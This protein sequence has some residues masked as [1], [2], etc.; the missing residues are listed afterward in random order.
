MKKVRFI[1]L[2]MCAIAFTACDNDKEFESTEFPVNEQVMEAFTLRYPDAVNVT[3]T[4]KGEYL[5]ANFD[6]DQTVQSKGDSSAEAH[7]AWFDNH[8]KWYMTE[9]DIPFS[10]LPE[11]VKTA[12]NDSEYSAAP[13]HVEDVDMLEREGMETIYVIEVENH[14][15]GIESEIVLYYSGDGI[16]VKMI[17]DSETDYDYSDYIPSQAENGITEFINARYPDARITEI[18][19]EHGMTEV[20]I[21]D[22]RV[23]RELLFDAH[24]N[25]L[26]TKTKI[27]RSDCPEIVL[28][29]LSASEYSSLRIDD[30]VHYSTPDSEYYRV[31]LKSSEGDLKVDITLD[32]VISLVESDKDENHN[33]GNGQILNETVAEFIASM[34]P[35]AVIKEYDYDDGYLKVEIR[36]ENK[37]KKVYFNGRNEWVYTKWDIRRSELPALVTNAIAASEWA[38][39]KIDDI[40]FITTP[41][42][43][44]YLVELEHGKKEVKLRIDANGNIL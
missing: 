23:P 13:W 19:H 35:G 38:E 33:H 4:N 29:A 25:W 7:S 26:Y 14:G 37:G 28:S 42:Q 11:A 18:D 39:Y 3:W 20:E 27:H 36:H 5:V 21:I 22:G 2:L 16:L 40:E 31:E 12:F 34:Y 6:L 1:F 44:Y 17:A 24:G 10:A 41:E 30:I 8:G 32:G 9:T 43:E 15:N